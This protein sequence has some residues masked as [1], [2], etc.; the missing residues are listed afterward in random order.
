MVIS[1]HVTSESKKI[2]FENL[3]CYSDFKNGQES[4]LRLWKIA[5]IDPKAKFRTSKMV[6]MAISEFLHSPEMDLVKIDF[7][8]NLSDKNDSLGTLECNLG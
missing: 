7:T 6:K 3:L 4:K 1:S 8:E 2:K 5:K